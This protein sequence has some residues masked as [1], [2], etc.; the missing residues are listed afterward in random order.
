[1]FLNLCI[2]TGSHNFKGPKGIT[3]DRQG[4]ISVVDSGNNRIKIF[5]GDGRF[6]C[7]FGKSGSRRGHLKGSEGLA[8]LTNGKLVVTDR[9]NHRIQVF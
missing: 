2:I 5:R 9:D 3:V 6:F 8:L 7:A 4:F 1:M